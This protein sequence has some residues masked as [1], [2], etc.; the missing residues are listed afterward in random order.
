MRHDARR[1]E[2]GR[3]RVAAAVALLVLAFGGCTSLEMRFGDD[4]SPR[5]ARAPADA[6]AGTTA[7]CGAYPFEAVWVDLRM[8]ARSFEAA[9]TAAGDPELDPEGCCWLPVLLMLP[10]DLALDA[11]LLPADLI[12]WTAGWRK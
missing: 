12:G 9:A 1:V 8:I 6:E 5:A 10:F 11:V 2:A 7:W 3:R 4:E